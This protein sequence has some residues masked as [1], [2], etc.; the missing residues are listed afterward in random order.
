VP[1]KLTNLTKK[2]RYPA[3]N[4]RNWS[5]IYNKNSLT[6]ICVEFFRRWSRLWA[7]VG[8]ET[9]SRR[10]LL[11]VLV[12]YVGLVGLVWLAQVPLRPSYKAQIRNRLS[13]ALQEQL[14]PPDRRPEKRS[15]AILAD[16]PETR[17]PEKLLGIIFRRSLHNQINTYSGS[18]CSYVLAELTVT[19][20][21][22]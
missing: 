9:R 5:Y 2:S 16:P 15:E 8:A 18:E 7:L 10:R 3:S 11:F 17:Q 21:V 6:I 19:K 14:K 1:I 4:V 20:I 22:R 13:D 12:L